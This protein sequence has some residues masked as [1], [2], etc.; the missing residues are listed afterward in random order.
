MKEKSVKFEVTVEVF[1]CSSKAKPPPKPLSMNQIVQPHA[2]LATL[3]NKMYL[4]KLHTD[5]TLVN[6]ALPF[7]LFLFLCTHGRGG[8]RLHALSHA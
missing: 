1:T 4:D 7:S 2:V 6:G 3:M 5:V 8:G